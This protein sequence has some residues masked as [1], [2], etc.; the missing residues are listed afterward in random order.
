MEYF[1]LGDMWEF[2][3][4]WS[5]YGVGTPVV[6]NDG[7]TLVQYYV[8]YLSAIQIYTNKSSPSL[9]RY[10]IYIQTIYFFMYAVIQINWQLDLES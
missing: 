1:T 3:N 8:P 9:I 2:Y 4:E 7:D 10:N 6:L 5:A